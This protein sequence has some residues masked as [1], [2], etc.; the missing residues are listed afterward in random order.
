MLTAKQVQDHYPQLVATMQAMPSH[1]EAMALEPHVADKVIQAWAR[2]QRGARLA[3]LMQGNGCP[4][5][6]IALL[7]EGQ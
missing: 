7:N 6:T 5:Q 4:H 3:L 2:L 1:I